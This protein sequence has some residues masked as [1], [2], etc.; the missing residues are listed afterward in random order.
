MNRFHT[1][2][3]FNLKDISNS[4]ES[5]AD[6]V[7]ERTRVWYIRGWGKTDRV[8]EREGRRRGI[9]RQTGPSALLCAEGRGGGGSTGVFST[10]Q[11]VGFGGGGGARGS[12]PRTHACPINSFGSGLKTSHPRI[13][14]LAFIMT[15]YKCLM[16]TVWVGSLQNAAF[17]T[18]CFL[19]FFCYDKKGFSSLTTKCTIYILYIRNQYHTNFNIL[20]HQK[21]LTCVNIYNSMI[22]TSALYIRMS[23]WLTLDQEG[24]AL[25]FQSWFECSAKGPVFI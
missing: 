1:L 4:H 19:I 24:T 15:H 12:S 20:H 10:T 13:Y 8:R 21:L 2:L 18:E 5:P 6:G 7:K 22:L 25:M 16:Q 17:S 3:A 11:D 9:C 23:P 14:G